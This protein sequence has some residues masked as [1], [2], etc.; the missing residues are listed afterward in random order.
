MSDVFDMDHLPGDLS[1]LTKHQMQALLDYWAAR[2]LKKLRWHQD[3]L[4]K[5]LPIAVK[6]KQHRTVKNIQ[7][8][9]EL[10]TDAILKGH[11]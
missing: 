6:H 10:L 7:I 4:E 5:Q 1:T 9:L 8:K 3:L 2:P 11:T